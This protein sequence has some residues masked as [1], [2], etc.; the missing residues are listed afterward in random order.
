MPDVDS[1]LRQEAQWKYIIASDLTK[2]FYQ[3]PL[4]RVS[5]EYCCVATPYKGV[6]VYVRSAMGMP[7]SETALEELTCQVLGDLV[8]AGCV[9]EVADDLYI[10]G[11]SFEELC[12]NWRN[13]LQALH[14]C[15]LNLSATKTTIAPRQTTILG[16]V[17]RL[18]TL[19]ASPHRLATLI[20]CSPPITVFGLR[21]FIGACKVLAR[22]VKGCS[23]LLS[24]LDEIVAGRE[25]KD[26]FL[27]SDGLLETFRK[28]QS[29]LSQSRTIALPRP[30]DQLWIVT[31]GAV[32]N[33]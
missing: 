21:S 8:E 15:N 26:T 5:M 17:W 32:R 24:Q 6:R 28:A 29:A 20:T 31:D 12:Q 18:G 23:A 9:A 11:N 13:V 2:S 22:V 7:G 27:W 10:G 14:R 4:S 1:T 30:S 25:S 19:Q 33:P 3:I 16:W